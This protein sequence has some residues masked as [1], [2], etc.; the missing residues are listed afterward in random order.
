MKKLRFSKTG[1][2]MKTLWQRLTLLLLCMA[3]LSAC[4]AI[5]PVGESA[6]TSSDA[7]TPAARQTTASPETDAPIARL[8]WN[9][10][11]ITYDP[12][13]WQAGQFPQTLFLQYATQMMSVMQKRLGTAPSG[14]SA[15]ARSDSATTPEIRFAYDGTLSEHEYRVEV[16]GTVQPD[17]LLFASTEKG[18]FGAVAY[19][20]E[21]C[22]PW[23]GSFPAET[24]MAAELLLMSDACVLLHDG[25]YYLPMRWEAG[26]AGYQGDERGYVMYKS[27]DLYHW[28]EPKL[29][30][31]ANTCTDPA[32]DGIC[33]FW[34][35]E[36]HEYHGKFY[37][38]ATYRSAATDHRGAAIFRSDTPDG[39]YE[40]IT[41]GHLQPEGW[42]AIDATL[43]VD[44][45]GN[46]WMIFV[47]EWT[48]MEDGIGDITAV[49]LSKDLTQTVGEFY[50]LFKANASPNY[51]NNNV[52]DGPW[53]YEMMDGKLAML[54]SGWGDGYFTCVAYSENGILGPWE[55]A[56]EPLFA[57]ENGI[58]ESVYGSGHAMLFHDQNGDLRMSLHAVY[59]SCTPFFLH[60]DSSDGVLKLK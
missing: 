18:I 34:A 13:E 50:P 2:R 25:T 35:P 47:H 33:D 1:G 11:R 19:F 45:D 22:L 9:Q 31:D 14:F 41:D 49:R 4:S 59:S 26:Y 43:Y 7:S 52:T 53:L 3:G 8:D 38:F 15:S 5:E 12:T 23:D 24:S 32:F 36:L 58:P 40:L 57:R 17:I 56:D 16:R 10:Y 30:F 46:P 42:D 29:V 37:L 51:P 60:I 54:W 21:D 55:Q 6:Q 48:S 39:T 44:P 20:F 27:T 28:S